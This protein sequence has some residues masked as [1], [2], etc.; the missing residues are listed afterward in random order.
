M[1]TV[2]DPVNQSSFLPPRRIALVGFVAAAFVLLP[3][4][5]GV[6]FNL[7]DV[8]RLNQY[9]VVLDSNAFFVFLALIPGFLGF[10]YHL[11]TVSDRRRKGLKIVQGFY[12][13]RNA[14]AARDNRKMVDI[15]PLEP[16]TKG[17]VSALGASAL[18]TGVF[19]FVAII[20]AFNKAT[21]GVNGIFFAG[22]GAYIAVLYLMIGRIYASALS[23]RFLMASA[24]G[25]AAA[26]TMGWA[27][28]NFGFA[29]VLPDAAA[30]AAVQT[31]AATDTTGTNAPATKPGTPP[32]P[33]APKANG[34]TAPGATPAAPAQKTGTTAPTG[35]TLMAEAVLFLIGISHK[36][37]Y[38]A[39]RARARK[40]FGAAEPE[41]VEVPI[42]V[43]EGID[44]ASAD[45]LNE[46]GVTS[47]QHLATAE[48]GEL[49]E[50]TLLPLDRVL[51]WIDQA[52][53]IERLKRSISGAR[54]IGIRGAVDLVIIWV[55][56]GGLPTSE[57]GK[58]LASLAETATCPLAR[59]T[60]SPN[61]SAK[62]FR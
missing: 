1:T 45:L 5:F 46:Y 55:K 51:R 38:D 22:L 7:S 43:V 18:L 15:Q 19:L 59:S 37:A 60:R 39:L 21:P 44:D 28:G 17:P 53:L 34:S 50:R 49:C 54:A 57:E 48:P 33:G 40:L 41:A 23:S 13:V 2:P 29:T 8:W 52:L 47:I 10:I 31:A 9:R 12:K 6:D 35:T 20:Y 26:I 42:A 32:Q 25:T 62:T 27:I 56:S 4:L 58:L 30:G 36:L 11:V 61:S 24:L 3:I 16:V 14:I